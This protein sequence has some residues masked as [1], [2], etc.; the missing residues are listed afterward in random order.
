MDTVSF[1]PAWVRVAWRSRGKC[2]QCGTG[3][4]DTTWAGNGWL[5]CW[6]CCA[7]R[8]ADGTSDSP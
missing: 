2:Q 8:Q 6:A 7:K 4:Q 1:V 3:P 5:I